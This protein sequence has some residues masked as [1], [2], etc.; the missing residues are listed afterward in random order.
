MKWGD[1]KP[2]M[3]CNTMTDGMSMM[4]WG[5]FSSLLALLLIFLFVVAVVVVVRRMWGKKDALDILKKR[6]AKGEIDIEEFERIKIEI[7]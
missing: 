6:Y 1:V 7:E 3:G 2:F 5:V 4:V